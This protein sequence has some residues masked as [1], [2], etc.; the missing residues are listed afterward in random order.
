[1]RR[2]PGKRSGAARERILAAAAK[3]LAHGGGELEVGDVARRARVSVGLAYHHFGSKAGL[4][5]A[6]IADF[7]ARHDAV[8]NQPLD[9]SLPWPTRE[10][11][12]LKGSVEFMYSDRLAPVMMGR[13]SGSIEVIALEASHRSAMVELAAANIAEGQKSGYIAAA[14]DRQIAAAAIIGGIRQAVAAALAAPKPPP[15]K[16]VVAQLWNFIAGGLSLSR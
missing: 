16:R 12:R 4:L 2:E 11:L 6:L 5:S 7:Y 10:R 1:M 3:A 13:L 8:A 14:I 9:R 15:S